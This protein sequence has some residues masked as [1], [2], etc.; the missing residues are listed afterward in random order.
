MAVAAADTMQIVNT[1]VY[2]RHLLGMSETSV[3]IAFA[4]DGGGSWS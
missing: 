1:V 3:A 4:A 2:V